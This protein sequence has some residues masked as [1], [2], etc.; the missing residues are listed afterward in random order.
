MT[1]VHA[2]ILAATDATT[3]LQAI[4]RIFNADTGT[5]HC[6]KA[7]GMLHLQ[8][9]HGF[10]PAPV[11]EHIQV[12]PVGKGMAGVCAQRDEPI[13]WCN[14]NNDGSGVVQSGARSLGLA[15]SIVVPIRSGAMLVG[16]LGIANKGERTFSDAETAL[17]MDCASSLARFC[18][19]SA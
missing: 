18:S 11:M 17:L 10:I 14:L 3:G 13:T 5:L 9:L 12:I 4:I 16:T 2:D 1:S 19:V 7:D 6:L 15:G 8:A